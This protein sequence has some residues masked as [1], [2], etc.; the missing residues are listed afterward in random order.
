[1]KGKKLILILIIINILSIS[2]IYNFIK[3]EYINNEKIIVKAMT[4][5][6]YENSIKELNTSHEDFVNYIKES[7]TQIASAITDM[8]VET[9]NEETLETMASNIKKIENGSSLIAFANGP[10]HAANTYNYYA[11]LNILDIASNY[12]SISTDRKTITALNSCTVGVILFSSY[13]GYVNV[14]Q[15]YSTCTCFVNDV[16]I[17]SSSNSDAIY[18]TIKLEAGDTLKFYYSVT[19][20]ASYGGAGVAIFME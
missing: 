18:K 14:Y 8:G 15:G 19:S 3:K 20:S 12:F 11:T 17:C 1:M 5:T 10:L 7:K 2:V 6:E 13:T 16:S 4:E 9:S